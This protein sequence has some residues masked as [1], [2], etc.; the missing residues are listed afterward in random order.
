MALAIAALAGCESELLPGEHEQ[1]I[2]GTA[3]FSDTWD[4]AQMD[5]IRAGLLVARDRMASP[6]MLDCL[7]ESQM[8]GPSTG[9]DQPLGTAYPEWIRS[10][11]LEDLPTNFAR[12]DYYLSAAVGIP[13]EE[14]LGL[15]ATDP[16][17]IAAKILH[18][19]G[20]NKGWMHVLTGEAGL[21][22]P[23]QLET[24][25]RDI[26]TGES[27][28]LGH[29]FT[30]RSAIA[31]ETTLAPV[32]L[33][34]GE[35]V[36][37]AC[38]GTQ[39]AAGLIGSTKSGLR[40][41]LNCREWGG[42]AMTETPVLGGIR[43]FSQTLL[44]CP[45]GSMMVGAWG[46]AGEGLGGIGILCATEAQIAAGGLQSQ[47]SSLVGSFRGAEWERKCPAGMVVKELRG[48]TTSVGGTVRAIELTCQSAANPQPILKS[49]YPLIGIRG[50]VTTIAREACI[51][52]GAVTSL[53]VTAGGGVA[54]V[55]GVCHPVR[56]SP[57]GIDFINDL[58][59]W[60][61]GVGPHDGDG[62]SGK[63]G[64][65]PDYNA[66]VGVRVGAGSP[67]SAV[68][69]LCA[70]VGDWGI[71]TTPVTPTPTEWLGGAPAFPSTDQLCPRG[72]FVGGFSIAAN[73]RVQALGIM[74]RD[75]Q[76]LTY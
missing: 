33:P 20:H 64:Y 12:P 24:C 9:P 55:A 34:I 3:T 76:G 30:P 25:S 67:L 35:G 66:L 51:G 21:S 32:G 13:N 14:V 31:Q 39:L 28:L 22:V 37:T 42:T 60:L 43:F 68:Q 6:A 18:E 19:V 63:E 57:D 58:P 47:R 44:S 56:T 45:E 41:G 71:P 75:F 15:A 52:R 69:G 5:R 73:S 4:P 72:Q 40:I 36:D 50:N 49:S 54:R 46:N 48:R 1:A 2:N 17:S 16:E 10:R 27:P 11:M 70:P 62:F 65:C 53:L 61:P 8:A 26:G 7:K 38:P 23:D 29:G 59:T 74:C